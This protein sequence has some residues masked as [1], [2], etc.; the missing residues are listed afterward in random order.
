MVG[1]TLPLGRDSQKVAK[2]K[3]QHSSHQNIV[4]SRE[5][6]DSKLK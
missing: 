2:T 6:T 4:V 3:H 5:K 1:V